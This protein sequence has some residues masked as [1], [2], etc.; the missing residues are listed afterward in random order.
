MVPL[1]GFRTGFPLTADYIISH[2]RIRH[3]FLALARH[4]SPESPLPMA[5]PMNV[6]MIVQMTVQ[7]RP[8]AK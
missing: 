1:A 3:P 6:P 5:V 4:L 2:I 7:V 8:D